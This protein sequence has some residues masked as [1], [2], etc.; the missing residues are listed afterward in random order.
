MF[1]MSLS[2]N[3]VRQG[4]GAPKSAAGN[5]GTPWAAAMASS[6]RIR[7]VAVGVTAPVIVGVA[8]P[9]GGVDEKPEALNRW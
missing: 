9:K 4:E 6:M 5:H 7:W 1:G 3:W 8:L 2:F